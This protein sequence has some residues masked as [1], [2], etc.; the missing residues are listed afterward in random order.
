[1]VEL[2]LHSPI[3]FDGV[4]LNSLNTET[5]LLLHNSGFQSKNMKVKATSKTRALVVGYYKK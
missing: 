3:S 5:T 4:V 1:M 2:Y